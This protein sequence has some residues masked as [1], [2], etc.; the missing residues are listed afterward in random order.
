MKHP[1]WKLFGLLSAFFLMSADNRCN[2]KKN[3]QTVDTCF[4]GKLEIKGG[5]MNYTISIREGKMD[6]ALFAPSWTDENT[7]KGYTNVFALESKCD[8]PAS[9]NEGDEF[10]FTIDS[11]VKRDCSVCMMYYPVPQKKLSIRVVSNPCPKP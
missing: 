9:I 4:K 2:S 5:C 6:T 8:F 3:K 10:Y 1:V 7:G 11:N